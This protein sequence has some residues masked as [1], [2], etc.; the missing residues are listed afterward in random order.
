[1]KKTLLFNFLLICFPAFAM[2]AT[3]T[4][5]PPTVTPVTNEDTPVTITLSASEKGYTGAF[6]YTATADNKGTVVIDPET[7][8]AVFTPKADYFGTEAFFK[9]T[10]TDSSGVVSSAKKVFVT[11]NSVNDAPIAKNVTGL[12]TEENTPITIDL[13]PYVSDVDDTDLNCHVSVRDDGKQKVYL[14]SVTMDEPSCQAV[15]TPTTGK[16]GDGYFKYYV[17]DASDGKSEEKKVSITIKE[18]NHAPVA[19]SQEVEGY[20]GVD[21]IITLSATDEDGDILTYS[22]VDEPVSGTVSLVDNVVTYSPGPNFYG[23]DSFTYQANDGMLSSEAEEV[24]VVVNPFFTGHETGSVSRTY[25][26][27]GTSVKIYLDSSY[28]D[29]PAL[30]IS[31][32]HGSLSY[33]PAA[34][35]DD[36]PYYIYTPEAGFLGKYKDDLFKIELSRTDEADM[37]QSTFLTVHIIV[38]KSSFENCEYAYKGKSG[39]VVWGRATYK[40]FNSTINSTKKSTV[41]TPIRRAHVALYDSEDNYL[42]AQTDDNGCYAISSVDESF[43]PVKISLIS[44]YAGNIKKDGYG[45]E[46]CD[47]GAVLNYSIGSSDEPFSYNYT[48]DSHDLESEKSEINLNE[49]T[50]T[51]TGATASGLEK[52]SDDSNFNFNNWYQTIFFDWNTLMASTEFVCSADEDNDFGSLKVLAVDGT[53]M[54]GSMYTKVEDGVISLGVSIPFGIRT[55]SLLS[56]YADH[57]LT[58]K[59]DNA[60]RDLENLEEIIG[61]EISLYDLDLRDEV[62]GRVAFYYGFMKAFHQVVREQYLYVEADDLDADGSFENDISTVTYVL[63]ESLF[64]DGYEYVHKILKS[65]WGKVK[66]IQ[67]FYSFAFLYNEESTT[68]KAKIGDVMSDTSGLFE[69]ESGISGLYDPKNVLGKFYGNKYAKF[70]TVA[71]LLYYGAPQLSMANSALATSSDTYISYITTVYERCT[72]GGDWPSCDSWE[73]FLRYL[74]GAWGTNC[75]YVTIE[76]EDGSD[77][78]YNCDPVMRSVDYSSELHGFYHT[79]LDD[80]T[81]RKSDARTDGYSYPSQYYQTPPLSG[82]INKEGNVLSYDSGEKSAISPLAS[83]WFLIPN[84]EHESLFSLETLTADTDIF[85]GVDV[86]YFTDDYNPKLHIADD[87]TGCDGSVKLT[88]IA[89]ATNDTG[90]EIYDQQ[91]GVCPS[92]TIPE[93][94][95]AALLE[96]RASDGKTN[97]SCFTIDDSRGCEADE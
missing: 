22:I 82:Y 48:F 47:D 34:S 46:N 40:G 94:G 27:D 37:V 69:D 71:T 18:T 9:F 90:L 7:G 68:M 14:G 4:A 97:V 74:D 2:A 8:V 51:K 21:S 43:V 24:G 17:T 55:S 41:D 52:W 31:P 15:Y 59:Y 36:E 28:T 42:L 45:W 79:S 66:A 54:G 70:P 96:V 13:K 23:Y 19:E 83:Q 67:D 62:D 92:V 75:T 86:T 38:D 1:M 95:T 78:T 26:T 30:Q 5:I 64:K 87:G 72:E 35:S 58:Y 39:K 12:E 60:R 57:L 77:E 65:D 76:T 3:P 80:Y 53:G 49:D 32:E 61:E 85:K 6:T 16:T 91:S 50:F 11:V 56:A 63:F 81:F 25:V 44:Y 33:I 84:G 73:Y 20:E 29:I 93:D 89:Y 10:V 88:L